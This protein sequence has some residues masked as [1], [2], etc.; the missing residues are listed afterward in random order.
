M[1]P[2]RQL[3]DFIRHPESGPHVV[4]IGGGTGLSTMLRGLKAYTSKLTAIV[5]VAD[6]GGSSGL[7]RRDLGILPPGDIRNCIMALA[8]VEPIMDRLMNHRFSEGSLAKQNFGNLFIAAMT[9][10]CDGN[11]YD[12][13]RNF[14]RVLAVTGK[15][16]PVSL[17]DIEIIAELSDGRTI[18]GESEIGE[19]ALPDGVRIERLRMEPADAVPLQEAIEEI[20]EADLIVL[21][22]GSLYTSIIPNLLF[23]PLVAAI[24]HTRATRVFVANIMTQPAETRGYDAADHLAAALRAAGL[25]SAHGFVD[26]CVVN[27]APIAPEILGRYLDS[28]AEP[29]APV[30]EAIAALGAT[31]IGMR[32]TQISDLRLRHDSASLAR[33]LM[34]LAIES[35]ERRVAEAST[36]IYTRLERQRNG[37]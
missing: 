8:D 5:T 4:V 35:I 29:V 3:D 20:E 13:V 19:H 2:I 9:D 23:A 7:L 17:S 22:P 12:A 28:L 33:L 11:F 24:Q 34:T 31:P 1:P 25:E 27:D 32:L 18:R 14:S 16:L 26:Y 30:P 37:H 15:V 36:R 6:D 21:G 10:V